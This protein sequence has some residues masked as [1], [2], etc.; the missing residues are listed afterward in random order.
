MAINVK[1]ICQLGEKANTDLEWQSFLFLMSLSKK[2][3]SMPM[4][5]MSTILTNVENFKPAR[6]QKKYVI[7]LARFKVFQ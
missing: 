7:E 3:Q 2:N 6:K 1:R 4:C 5:L